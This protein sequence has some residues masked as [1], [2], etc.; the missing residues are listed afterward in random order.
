MMR[1][2]LMTIMAAIVMISPIWSTDFARL[3]EKGNRAFEKG[4]FGKA[5]DFYHEA[6]IEKPETPEIYYNQG[7]TL[8][9]LGKYEEAIEKYDKALYSE[10]I[11]IQADAYFNQGNGYSMKGDF[12][13]AINC[14]EQYLTLRPDDADAKFNL[15]LARNKLK[16]Q[17]ERRPKGQNQG[18]GQGQK[19][20]QSQDQQGQ[21]Q[22]NQDQQNQNQQDQEPPGPDQ[23][24]EDQ[25]DE[26]EGGEEQLHKGDEK[27]QGK[28]DQ[29]QG[30]QKEDSTDGEKNQDPNGNETVEDSIVDGFGQGNGSDNDATDSLTGQEQEMTVQD[31]VRILNSLDDMSDNQQKRKYTIRNSDYRG[32]DW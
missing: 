28:G 17:M 12:V 16:E 13:N 10:D 21:G 25:P 20:D 22:P 30:D 8:L 3:N 31:A 5:L 6:E 4:D 32:E 27:E 19:Q 2:I 1:R 7:N 29:D 26:G 24:D 23:F 11:N 14:F 15:E 18:Q 9:K